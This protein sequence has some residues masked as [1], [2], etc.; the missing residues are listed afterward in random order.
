M[1]LRLYLSVLAMLVVVASCRRAS[2]FDEKVEGHDYEQYNT[3]AWV[4]TEEDDDENGNNLRINSEIHIENIKSA[5][6]TQM[7]ER[8]FELDTENPDILL[9]VDTETETRREMIT[10]G[11]AF[12]WGGMW[13]PGFYGWGHPYRGW[14]AWGHPWGAWGG[15]G[16]WGHPYGGWGGWGHGVRQ[17]HYQYATIVVDMFDRRN[18]Q[19]IWRGG[20][21]KRV[22]N[23]QRFQERIPRHVCIM[24]EDFP[25]D[26]E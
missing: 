11:P 8:G 3:Y 23:P 14:G 15:W 25:V 9:R 12:G 19:H 2:Y 24:F 16:G 22:N 6:N 5:V 18:N 10:T 4:P 20:I 7:R 26:R 21:E 13:G 17:V 1:K